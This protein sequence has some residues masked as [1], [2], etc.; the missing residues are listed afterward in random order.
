VTT[1][2]RSSFTAGLRAVADFLDEHPEVRLPYLGAYAEGSDL[3]SLPIYL[4]T[5][6]TARDEL[7]AI[8]RAM[9][10]ATKAVKQFAVGGDSFQVWREF[11]GIVLCAGVDRGEVCTKVVTGTE[12]R[13]V[14]EV[15]TPAVTR[16]VVKQ[17]EVVEW[18]CEPLLAPAPDLVIPPT[19]EQDEPRFA[20]P[21]PLTV[22]PGQP[23]AECGQCG[24]TGMIR[25]LAGE[26]GWICWNTQRCAQRRAKAGTR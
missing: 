8:T 2:N 25:V 16:K 23:P 14:E 12:D 22:P 19:D 1:E 11:E 3:P 4:V 5:G 20:E 18:K 7:A 15:V 17:V 24:A 21:A 9:G 6:A 26:D 13:E 10:T